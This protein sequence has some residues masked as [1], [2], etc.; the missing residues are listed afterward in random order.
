LA[1]ASALAGDAMARLWTPE[2]KPA[3]DY[4]R[5]RGLSDATI[6]S[7]HLGF[8]PEVWLPTKDGDRYFRFSGIT[9][10]S[11]D[12]DRLTRIKIRRIDGGQPKYAQAYSDR[13]LIYPDPAAIWPGKPLIIC[14]GEFDC[15]LL[16]QEL[17]EASV[18][19][20]GSASVRTDSAV[21]SRMLSAPRWFI[22]L[23]ADK[24]GDSAAAKFPGNTIRVRPPEPY[25]DW[26]EVH[27]G[28]FN[29]IRY[30]WGRYLPLSKSWAEL[31]PKGDLTPH[32]EDGP[33]PYAALEREAIRAE[34]PT[35]DNELAA[36][37]RSI[38]HEGA[39]ARL[40]DSHSKEMIKVGR[41]AGSLVTSPSP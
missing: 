41:G 12:G 1:E 28:G 30:H 38:G 23:D 26:G 21:L 20:L 25:K 3:L 19:T 34:P 14:E 40:T 37:L 13:P 6:K 11:G 4:L 9:I 36:C 27:A 39:A 15:L 24:A 2:G 8:T 7:V 35:C 10:P 17:P 29:Q 18:I 16:G 31:E 22:A 33:D 5:S 32:P